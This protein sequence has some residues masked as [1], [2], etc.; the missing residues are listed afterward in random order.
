MTIDVFL[1][2]I[3]RVIENICCLLLLLVLK[4]SERSSSSSSAKKPTPK[5]NK[6]KSKEMEGNHKTDSLISVETLLDKLI[7]IECRMKDNFSNL[8]SQISELT[9]EFKQEI[10]VVKSTLNE[11]E[12][13]ASN[14]WAS[15]KD[16][17]Q[18]SKALKDSKS[19]HQK[20]TDEQ[21][22][23][24]RGLK[25]ALKKLQAEKEKL[26]PAFK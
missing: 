22:A 26:K 20:M 5:R 19:T 10:N 15:I 8:H 18:L 21:T 17:Q 23:E 9:C 2:P 1:T 11:L 6:Q 13:S 24:I 16:L 12:K 7:A 3:H 14:P 4:H 25:A